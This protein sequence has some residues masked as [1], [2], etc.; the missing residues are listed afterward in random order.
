MKKIPTRY[1]IIAGIAFAVALTVFLIVFFNRSV[2]V[3][4][5]LGQSLEMAA[6]TLDKAGFKVKTS[7]E[8]S[9]TISKDIVI[10]QDIAGG[11]EKKHGS[12]ITIVVSR[13]IEQIT[14]PDLKDCP[15]T[16]AKATLEKL[17]FSV[18]VSEQFSKTVAKGN[19]IDQS[20]S[21]G[22][23][24][25]KG[26]S[27]RL[28]VS[29]G[30]DLVTVP[31]VRGMT[32]QDARLALSDAGLYLETQSTIQFSNTVKEGYI[33]SQDVEQNTQVDRHA[34]VR[35]VVSAGVANTA[36]TTHSNANNYGKVTTQGDWVY[37][38]GDDRCIYKMRDDKSDKQRI[39]K[40]PAVCLNVVGEWIYY[41]DG[42]S[43][44]MFKVRI[45]GTD[46]TKL[47]SV[48]SYKLYVE[49]DWIYYTSEYSGGM[50]YKM[51][52]DGSS[53][54]QIFSEN[55]KE[56]IVH[57]GYVYYISASDGMV[58]KCTTDGKDRAAVCDGFGGTRLCLADQKLVV[59]N[60][61]DIL[62]VNLDGSGYTSFGTTNVQYGYLNSKDGWIYYLESDFRNGNDM[63]VIG[64]MKPDGSDKTDIFEYKYLN[65]AN[66]Y[67]N[68]ANGW[69]Y[70]KNEGE[71]DS[72]YRVKIDGSNCERVA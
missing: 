9:D 2:T 31:D 68:V 5:V 67:L 45:D 30:R 61:Y 35:A 18:V 26:L 55:C 3:P 29:R 27:I 46:N 70:F 22:Q 19:V 36:G 28:T 41:T 71:N 64:R 11:S 66:Y 21:A 38:V 49:G 58:Y 1:L 10:S 37:F 65:H 42:T 57:E 72:L 23:P 15:V 7:L 44:G 50:L 4:D 12:Q 13:G 60:R 39:G 24:V 14:L 40:F 48:T 63:S 17:G 47:S 51:K 62:S 69:I 52:T 16:E 54:T 8:Y 59:V 33:I 6:K 25:D 34:T 43:G 53:V 20:V 56:F 32:A